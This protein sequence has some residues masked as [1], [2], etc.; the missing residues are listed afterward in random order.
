MIVFGSHL[1]IAGGM[2]NA[3][4]KA[5]E[6]GMGCVQVFTKNQKQWKAPPLT[7]A[8]IDTWLEHM[9]SAGITEVVSH[10]SYLINLASPK[11]DIR[12]K[13]FALY[14]E[15]LIRCHALG[16]PN[17]VM[18]PGAH[19]GTGEDQGLARVAESLNRVHDVLP[20]VA[21]TTCLEITAGQGTGLGYTFEHLAA[22]IDQVDADD[23]L[24]V[25]LDTAH[26]IAAGYDLTS[27]AGAKAVLKEC[28]RVIGLERIRVLH[29]NDSKVERGRRVDRHEHIGKGFVS[30]DAFAVFIN[31]PKLRKLPMILETPKDDAPDGR[32]WDLVNLET[33]RG[34]AKPPRK[35]SK[36]RVVKKS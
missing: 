23:R 13:S 1:S 30:L 36:K 26:L 7:T 6:L 4:V 16:I 27:Q 18:H 19:L 2:E 28:D 20:D 10:D 15:E 32:P 14:G 31:H 9:A 21:V 24:G 12:G 8:Q 17:L 34:L 5:R 11:D 29:L 33:L 35:S 25:C 3:L 22:I